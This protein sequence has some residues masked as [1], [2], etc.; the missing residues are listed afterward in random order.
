MLKNQDAGSRQTKFDSRA[1]FVKTTLHLA[2]HLAALTI[3][4]ANPFQL[5]AQIV[6]NDSNVV[7]TSELELSRSSRRNAKP[8]PRTP[9]IEPNSQSAS[10]GVAKV[11][12]FIPD[13]DLKIDLQTQ[14]Q[15]SAADRLPALSTH[16]I[17]IDSKT[18]PPR[19]QV[20]M[21]TPATRLTQPELSI[22]QDLD[23]NISTKAA[24]HV[25]VAASQQPNRNPI[26]ANQRISFQ[27]GYTLDLGITPISKLDVRTEP[28]GTS[29]PQDLAAQVFDKVVKIE[30]VPDCGIACRWHQYGPTAADF[31]YQPLFWEEINLE[32]HGTN[33]GRLQP[34]FSATKFFGT[35]PLLPYKMTQQPPASHF[36]KANA[37]PAGLPAP[38]APEAWPYSRKAGLAEGVAI[39]AAIL[40]FP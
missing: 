17:V 38:W 27:D 15:K 25:A 4:A 37:Q 36:R 20:P 16:Q 9:S 30:Y 33:V 26:F 8:L 29:A 19:N 18:E 13:L 1:R 34:V 22:K 21:G 31:G 24:H 3:L 28:E 11:S 6:Q 40:I 14:N 23:H 5:E 7:Q 2:K 39:G 35:F 12:F 10:A 32:R